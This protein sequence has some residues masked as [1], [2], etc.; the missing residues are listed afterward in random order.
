MTNSITNP[1]QITGAQATSTPVPNYT[2]INAYNCIQTFYLDPDAVAKSS[3]CSLTSV[4]LYFKPKVGSTGT[5]VPSVQIG[6]CEIENDE[7][8]LAKVYSGSIV[9]VPSDRIN[10]GFDD[11]SVLT[12]F[13]FNTP[14]HVQSGK[15]YG[16]VVVFPENTWFQ[17]WVNRQGDA[18]VGTN[19][20]S[21]GSNAV[22]DGKFFQS[23]Q[24]VEGASNVFKA[25]SDTDLKFAVKVAK[26]TANTAS[27]DVYNKNY[28]FF[29]INDRT[30]TFVGGELVYA[31]TAN[32]TGTVAIASGNNIILGTGTTFTS[33][34]VGDYLTAVSN[35]THHQTLQIAAIANATQMTVADKP[36]WSNSVSKYKIAPVGKVF[37]KNE[38]ANFMYLVDS[39]ANVGLKFLTNQYIV[40]D[41]SNASANVKSIDILKV[42]R[43]N[44][45]APVN[46]P[47]SAELSCNWVFAYSNGSH[48]IIDDTKAKKIDFR[49]DAVQDVKD[50]K[51]R[52]LS[53]SLEVSEAYLSGT[54][55][56]SV[57]F[58]K[59]LAIKKP[60]DD[61]YDTPS[62]PADELD[63]LVYENMCGNSSVAYATDTR[64]VSID[65]EVAGNG[66]ADA[67]H[68][69]SKVTFANNRFA[70]DV[71]M[72]MTAYRPTGT[73]IQVYAK[74]QNS[75][76]SETFD[77]KSWTPLTYVDNGANYS[78]TEDET[79]LI[80]YELGLPEYSP[81]A[82]TLAG[83]FTSNGTNIIEYSTTDANTHILPNDV[84]RFYSP[85]FPDNWQVAVCTDS[86]NTTITAGALIG[87]NTNV[88]GSGFKVDRLKY[89][90]T[91]FN[92]IQSDNVS[93]YYSKSLVEYDKFD[94]MQIKIVFYADTPNKVPKIDQIQVIGVSA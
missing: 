65:T 30:G 94:S 59:N 67:R 93:R 61:I 31:N 54:S 84:F 8:N 52:I 47:S 3:A 88:L 27:V 28:E 73:D 24:Y 14:L 53:R 36:R 26:Y 74:L 39:S 51:G 77:E 69:T 64:G 57:H 10:Y 76:D 49:L 56:K 48:Y 34:V 19:T 75:S 44:Y 71:R 42:D 66:L 12:N 68:I 33:L 87:S 90:N 62:V 16:I 58:V 7:P 86:N 78:S 79:N 2:T 85:L 35:A 38:L 15:W 4:D 32:A 13:K 20:A 11:A 43:F 82:N 21:S 45:K 5:P 55:R 17:T 81:T 25:L 46:L 18:L 80:E 1:D 92:N 41:V 6:I 22:K 23:G 40:G 91:A 50:Y 37:Y 63:I 60:T 89:Y 83:T 70:E 29:T 9:S 72:Y